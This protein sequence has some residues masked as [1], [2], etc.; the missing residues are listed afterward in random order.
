VHFHCL[1]LD[2]QPVLASC[3]GASTADR[4]FDHALLMRDI[5]HEWIGR[6]PLDA[7]A[8]VHDQQA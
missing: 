4:Q 7:I 5:E 2:G 3:Y 8:S 6:E 1:V